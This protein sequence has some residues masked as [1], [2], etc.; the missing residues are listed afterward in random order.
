MSADLFVERQSKSY[1]LKAEINVIRENA[2]RLDLMTGL[3]LMLATI[4]LTDSKIEYVLY[5]DKKY[6]SGKPN[7]HALDPVFP[8]AID[9]M[10]LTNILYERTTP[11]DCELDLSGFPKQCRGVA[12]K[13]PYNVTW[14]K[15]LTAGPLA[16]RA[17]KIVLD[18][19]QRQVSLKFYFNDL[20]KNIGNAERLLSLQVPAGFK[21]MP[22][23]DRS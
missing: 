12:G 13:T 21:S 8:L 17:S 15:R 3:D 19:P 6:Y 20:K 9:V 2:V 5:R 7:P 4:I 14:S 11:G 1:K 18:L 23:P 16:G 22:V 10:A